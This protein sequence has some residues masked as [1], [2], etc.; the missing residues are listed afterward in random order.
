[1]SGHKGIR[2]VSAKEKLDR[3]GEA[4]VAGGVSIVNDGVVGGEP[5]LSHDEVNAR[6]E[7]RGKHKGWE[8]GG[9]GAVVDARERNG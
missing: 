4:K 6:R 7:G 8:M 3:S 5:V 1:M 9:I 2:G